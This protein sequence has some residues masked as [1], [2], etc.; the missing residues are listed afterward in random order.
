ML[1]VSPWRAGAGP[2]RARRPGPAGDRRHA[3]PRRRLARRDR[4]RARPA[5]EPGRPPREGARRTPACSCGPGPRATGA[6]PTCGWCRDALAALAPPPLRAG[7]A[8]GVRVHPQL[9]PLPARRRAVARQRSGARRRRPAPSRPPGCT[10]ARSGSPAGTAST[11][12]PTGTAHVADV[13]RAGDL[14]IAVCDNAHET[15]PAAARPPAALVGARPGP[16]RH[17]RRVRSRLHRPRRPHR[18]ARTRRSP[19]GADR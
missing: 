12:D 3:Q 4:P 11:L 2:R 15:C 17:R 14:V 9:G 16:G 5:D 6:A 13:V 7:R 8:G 10:P 19:A 18:P 1:S